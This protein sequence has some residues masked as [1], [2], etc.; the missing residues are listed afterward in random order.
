[1]IIC[2]ELSSQDYQ[3]TYLA[4]RHVPFPF[5]TSACI[6]NPGIGLGP[7]YHPSGC[8]SSYTIHF[9]LQLL[10]CLATFLEYFPP[11]TIPSILSV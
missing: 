7:S 8:A 2:Q 1:M 11:Y 4:S 10:R 9:P 6:S 5:C 3:D